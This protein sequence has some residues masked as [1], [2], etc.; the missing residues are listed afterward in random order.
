MTDPGPLQPIQPRDALA[1][2]VANYVSNGYRV[3]MQT[4]TQAV[5]VRGRRPNHLLHFL[6]GI[7]TL[8]LWWIFVWLPIAIIGGEKRLVITVRPDGQIN[9]AK[10][11]G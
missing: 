9:V 2:A 1:Q 8:S 7:F 6:I 5:L 3:E 11:R 4:E 10:G